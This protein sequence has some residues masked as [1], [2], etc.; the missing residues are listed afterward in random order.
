MKGCRHFPLKG[1]TVQLYQR[2]AEECNVELSEKEVGLFF[3]ALRGEPKRFVEIISG[4]Q[5]Q[6]NGE[7][8]HAR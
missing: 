6:A 3:E 5:Q 2:Y 8:R 1:V 4:R 7:F